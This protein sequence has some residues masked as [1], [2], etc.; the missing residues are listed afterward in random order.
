[1]VQDE[2]IIVKVDSD[3]EDIIPGF[4]QKRQEDIKEIQVALDN[5]NYDTIKVLGHKMKGVGGG[6]GFDAITDIGGMIEQAAMEKNM[7]EVKQAILELAQY[8]EKVEVVY[9]GQDN[10]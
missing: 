7:Q 10:G 3:L 5:D 8:L 9:G 6:Y 2:K 4:L 1:M